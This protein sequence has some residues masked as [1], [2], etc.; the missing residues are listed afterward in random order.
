MSADGSQLTIALG[1]IAAGATRTI[2]YAMSVRAD[3]P[4]GQAL[5]RAVATDARGNQSVASANLLIERETIA[6]R[7][8][9]VRRITR[10]D[11]A[12]T[13]PREGIAGVRVVLE[14]GSFVLTDIDGCYHFD[15]LVPGTHVVQA[16]ASTLPGTGGKFIDC[17]ASSRSAG[18]PNS[19]FV[20]GRGGSLVVADFAAI[21]GENAAASTPAAKETSVSDPAAAGAGIDFVG[22][23]DGPDEFLFPALD[24]NPRAR[25]PSASRSATVRGTRSNSASMARRPTSARSTGPS[26][27]RP[28]RMRSASGAA[29]RSMATPPAWPRG[30]RTPAER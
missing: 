15:G 22:M 24:H 26:L 10:G 5:N 19:R 1:D 6:G 27:R 13:G 18:T 30:S 16:Q 9:L 17:T 11:C 12:L 4:P 14:D 3:A 8:T 23:G 29:F 20:T 21:I 7:M 28:T 25:A 2:V